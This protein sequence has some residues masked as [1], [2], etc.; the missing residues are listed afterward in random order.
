MEFEAIWSRII[1]CAGQP[2]ATKR[3]LPF[4]YRIVNGAVVPDR[5]GY[6]LSRANFVKA[7]GIEN[8]T[9]PGQISN[10]VRGPAYVYAI[11][12]DPRVRG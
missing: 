12:T 7:A 10:L 11:L 2:F 1:G 9:G 3:G 4:T 8:L 6:A 5:T